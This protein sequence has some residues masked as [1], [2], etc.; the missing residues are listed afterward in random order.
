MKHI[1]TF[2]AGLLL[3]LCASTPALS[4]SATMPDQIQYGGKTLVLNGVGVRTKLF[5]KLYFGG[6]YLTQKNKDAAAII[7]A[8]EPM[9]IRLVITSSMISPDRMKAATLEGFQIAT[10]GNLAPIQPQITKLLNSFDKGVG[11]GDI[12]ELINMPGSGVHVVRNGKLVEKIS[13]LPFKQALFGIW[14]S[15]KPVQANLRA[16]MLGL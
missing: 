3:A 13:S 12:Y 7:A 9:S 8:D 16:Q 10:Q 6:L 4:A 11:P 1:Y 14:L 2:V 5:M 15:N